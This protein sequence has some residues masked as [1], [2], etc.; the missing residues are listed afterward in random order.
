MRGKRRQGR[1]NRGKIGEI[2]GLKDDYRKER[3]I[4]GMDIQG[5]E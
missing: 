4:Q 5:E 1:H 2:S 3:V